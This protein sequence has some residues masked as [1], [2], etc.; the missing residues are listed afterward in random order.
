LAAAVLVAAFLAVVFLV[1]AFLAV[2]FVVALFLAVP[3]RDFSGRFIDGG[4]RSLY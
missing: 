1:A 4:S 3:G 2:D